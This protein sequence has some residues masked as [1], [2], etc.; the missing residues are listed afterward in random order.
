MTLPEETGTVALQAKGYKQI[1]NLV[2]A[3]SYFLYIWNANSW[4]ASGTTTMS[5]YGTASTPTASLSTSY[6][7]Y[8]PR[9]VCFV[10]TSDC[11]VDKIRFPHYWYS[12]YASTLLLKM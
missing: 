2:G 11:T 4:V 9:A 6:E 7:H 5:I 1:I 12:S 10:A 3:S 8:L